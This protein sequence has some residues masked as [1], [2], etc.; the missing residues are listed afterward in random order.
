MP[1]MNNISL[2]R[3]SILS[4]IVHNKSNGITVD[5]IQSYLSQ[6]DLKY[7]DSRSQSYRIRNFLKK[8]ERSKSIKHECDFISRR[9]KKGRIRVYR[10]YSYYPTTAGIEYYLHFSRLMHLSYL[11]NCNYPLYQ[12]AV[13]Q[14]K[15]ESLPVSAGV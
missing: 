2:L 15:E 10:S 7:I 1:N 11:A 5:D 9:D 4:C 14:I 12:A 13:N 6:F 8:L 3:Y